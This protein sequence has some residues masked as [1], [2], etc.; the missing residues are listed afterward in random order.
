MNLSAET[1]NF[2]SVSDRTWKGF[3]NATE[4]NRAWD[5]ATIDI[6]SFTELSFRLLPLGIILRPRVTTPAAL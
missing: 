1:F 2:L 3:D 4:L 5:L 6:N